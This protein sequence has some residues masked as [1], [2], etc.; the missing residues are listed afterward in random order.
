MGLKDQIL[1]DIKDAMKSKDAQSL[2]VLRLINSALKNKEIEVRPKE[3][4]EEDCLAVLKKM[5]KQHKDSIEQFTKAE[6]QDLVEK[7]KSEL[8]VVER[9]LPEQMSE[10]KVKE[11]VMQVIQELG[12]SSMK[13]MGQVMKA[14]GAKTAGTAD[15]KL[16][17]Q[18]VKANLQ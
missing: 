7:E 11:V 18:L 15:N 8:S 14:V 10:D 13:D 17:S 16:V 5:G 6:R 1:S 9:Y 3:L 12:A 4:T 2:S